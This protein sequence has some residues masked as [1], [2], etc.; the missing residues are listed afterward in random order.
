MA[1]NR[2]ITLSRR[3]V[4]RHPRFDTPRKVNTLLESPRKQHRRI[5]GNQPDS[6]KGD[7]QEMWMSRHLAISKI[8]TAPAAV[9]LGLPAFA[10]LEGGR[11][12]RRLCVYLAI[13][14]RGP[15]KMRNWNGW[16]GSPHAMAK[17]PNCG[18]H[19]QPMR[20]ASH[21]SDRAMLGSSDG[22]QGQ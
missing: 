20:S 19:R 14:E 11:W 10:D 15:G 2:A 13:S 7:T 9:G 3:I 17:R 22:T 21:E 6:G 4:I 5:L 12:P 8:I 16:L 18:S 1:Y